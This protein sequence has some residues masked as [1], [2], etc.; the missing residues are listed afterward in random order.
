MKKKICIAL[1][2]MALL[3]SSCGDH[4]KKI[5]L[6][7]SQKAAVDISASH[8]D[9][10]REVRDGLSYWGLANRVYFW[11]QNENI[12]LFAGY[13][14]PTGD[15]LLSDGKTPISS[16]IYCMNS[17][18]ITDDGIKKVATENKQIFAW[19]AN[20]VP[21][22]VDTMTDDELRSALEEAFCVYLQ[23]STQ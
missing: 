14:Q 12:Y 21:I 20:G 13:Y 4:H 7:D 16:Y 17:Y 10:W 18:R 23:K 1:L 11:E 2:L 6:T 19:M 22:N 9:E 15:G 3:M 5:E 8:K